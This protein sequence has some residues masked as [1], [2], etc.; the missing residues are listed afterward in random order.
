MKVAVYDTYVTRKDGG[1]M[2]FDILV[3]DSLR[4]EQAIHSFGKTYLSRKDQDGQPLTTS[5]CRFCHIEEASEE[6]VQDIQQQG[7]SII[8]MQGCN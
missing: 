1:L 4:D 3:P 8:E 2:H 5:E 7:F 6:I